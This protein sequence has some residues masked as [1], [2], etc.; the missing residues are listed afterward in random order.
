MKNGHKL[1][2]FIPKEERISKLDSVNNMATDGLAMQGA[3]ASEA[4]FFTYFA[5][6]IPV[7]APEGFNFPLHCSIL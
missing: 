1:V 2:K 4:V 3:K 6:N 7:S 5:Q